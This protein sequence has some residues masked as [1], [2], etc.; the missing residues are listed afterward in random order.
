MT[1]LFSR[2]KT[3]GLAIAVGVAGVLAVIAR[4]LLARNSR[5]RHRAESAEQKAKRAV[6]IMQADQDIEKAKEKLREEQKKSDYNG[7]N[8]PDSL[9]RKPDDS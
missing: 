5:L 3:Y 9:W 8:D 7:F 1:L 4:L 2:I 6:I